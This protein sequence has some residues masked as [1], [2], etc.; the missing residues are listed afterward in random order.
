MPGTFSVPP[1][2][3][4]S[5]GPPRSSASKLALA[6]HHQRAHALRALRA[7]APRAR[8]RRAPR[9]GRSTGSLP[10]HCVASACTRTPRA[11]ASLG[12]ARHRLH[13]ARLVVRPEQRHQGR[14]RP[15]RGRQ[16]L[17]IQQAVAATRAARVTRQPSR[18]SAASGSS[19]DGCSAFE[20]TTWRLLAG[21]GAQQRREHGVVRLGRAG[22]E[23]HLARL[24]AEQR[25]HA[26]ARALHLG[27]RRGAL[28]VNARGIARS[29]RAAR[30]AS[31]PPPR[32]APAWWRCDR[33]R[34]AS[35]RS[36]VSRAGSAREQI[37]QRCGR[38][39]PSRRRRRAR[40]ARLAPRALTSRIASRLLAHAAQRRH[41]LGH[42]NRLR[43]AAEL[44][45]A[46]LR[47]PR[48]APPRSRARSRSA[49]TVA[50]RAHRHVERLGEPRRRSRP[51]RRRGSARATSSAM[52]RPIASR[53]AGEA[54]RPR[55]S[56]R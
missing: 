32:R 10:R 48:R 37:G 50:H 34:C 30:A 8:A 39:R 21:P 42:R 35:G 5:C 33:G 20:L 14:V 27:A 52:R 18:S 12:E 53:S 56:R 1:R 51:A 22:R 40:R 17:R 6:A 38:R 49:S 55:T 54:A 41:H 31:P 11:R 44:V 4:R 28:G 15:E 16:R 7:C 46:L 43:R 24:A 23:E 19:T 29:S 13:H 47:R 3:R 36:P 45:A 2:R 26:L 25:R 9:R